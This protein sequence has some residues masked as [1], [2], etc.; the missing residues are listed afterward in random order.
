M[1]NISHSVL[2]QAICH[3]AGNDMNKLAIITQKEK[4]DYDILW[5]NILHMAAYLQS[6]DL[7][8]GD[9]IL[10]SALKEIEFVYLY[11]ASHLLGLTNVIIDPTSNEARKKYILGLT[12]PKVF[13]GLK[14]EKRGIRYEDIV[15]PDTTPSINYSVSADDVAD[16]M[17]TTGTTGEPKGVLLSYANIDASARNI[18]GFIGNTAGD[19]EALGLP[20]CHSFGLGRL[21]CNFLVGATVVLLGSFANLKVFFEAFEKYHVTGFGMVPA[22]WEY[23]KKLSRDRIGNYREQVRYIEIGSAAMSVADKK[24][25]CELFPSTRICMHY[26]MTEASRSLFMEFHENKSDLTT[27]GLPVSDLVDVKIIDE[28]GKEVPDGEAGEIC[29][30]GNM[31]MKSYFLPEDSRKAF[32]GKYFRTGDY[33]YRGTGGKYYLISRKK[34]LINVGGKKVS[35]VEIEEAVM[36]LGVKDCICTAI[37]DP[38]GMLGEVPKLY[39]L[40]EGTSLGLDEIAGKLI[41]VLEHYKLPVQYE[42]I[43]KIPVTVSGKKQRLKMESE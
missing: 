17:F 13:F 34:E 28:D 18:N 4:I 12:K 21:R 23:V 19:V 11:F 15:L 24:Q 20:V 39:V 37:K 33:G 36:A 41:S 1:Y 9:Y 32:W 43:D 8:Q 38:R 25:L 6:L 42:W 10:L 29:V 22:V 31:V 26:G 14:E 16:V 40:K 5:T 35:P 7:K 30:A 2:L 27:I 3:Y